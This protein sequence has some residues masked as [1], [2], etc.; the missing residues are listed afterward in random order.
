MENA[1]KHFKIEKKKG[2]E[3]N[4]VLKQIY[5]FYDTEQETILRK[6]ENWKRYIKYL[7]DNK[8]Q[9]SE[10]QIKKFKRNKLFLKKLSS[11]SIAFFLSHVKVN[12]LYY[13]LSVVKDKSFRRESVGSYIMSLHK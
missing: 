5:S 12:D 7:K 8:L 4:D 11:A 6:K 9:S 3:R 2:S 10:E 13:V 1:F